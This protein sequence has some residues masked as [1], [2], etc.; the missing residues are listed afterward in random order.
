MA[1]AV[2]FPRADADAARGSAPHSNV[3]AFTR[4]EELAAYRDMLLIRR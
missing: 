4:E 1:V 3:A 2:Q